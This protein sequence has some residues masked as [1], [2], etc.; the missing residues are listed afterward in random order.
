[1]CRKPVI[2]ASVCFHHAPS[3]V[4]TQ[5]GINPSLLLSVRS[6]DRILPKYSI[7][8][9]NIQHCQSWLLASLKIFHLFSLFSMF[10]IEWGP[11]YLILEPHD[12]RGRNPRMAILIE[13]EKSPSLARP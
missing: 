8:E 2:K 13:V 1:M 3:F 11:T 4:Q 6:Y 7:E 9:N 5:N 10:L 12:G